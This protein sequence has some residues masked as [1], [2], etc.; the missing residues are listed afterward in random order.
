MHVEGHLLEDQ[1]DVGE[2]LGNHRLITSTSLLYGFLQ[3]HSANVSAAKGG[4]RQRQQVPEEGGHQGG[5][6]QQVEG[7]QEEDHR[8]HD[9]VGKDD[10]EVAGHLQA[11]AEAK[12]GRHALDQSEEKLPKKSKKEKF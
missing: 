5:R 12:V 4:H 2:H 7:L 11:A 8:L 1:V 10:A 3:Q 6:R 9:D